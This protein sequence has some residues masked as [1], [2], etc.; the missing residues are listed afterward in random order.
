M[1]RKSVLVG[2]SESHL[3]LLLTL[4]NIKLG[5]DFCATESLINDVLQP[6]FYLNCHGF[7]LPLMVLS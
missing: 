4:S 6:W 2:D 1:F 3:N 5:E 7:I